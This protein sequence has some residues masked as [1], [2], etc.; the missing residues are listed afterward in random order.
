M[1][2]ESVQRILSLVNSSAKASSFK[3]S[4]VST[5]GSWRMSWQFT[6]LSLRI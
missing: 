3:I 5:Y 1:F 6:D 2:L 4:R